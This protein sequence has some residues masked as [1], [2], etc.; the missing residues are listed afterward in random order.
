MYVH[1]NEFPVT[2]T[3]IETFPEALTRK[4]KVIFFIYLFEKF[5]VLDVS[6][7]FEDLYLLQP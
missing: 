7:L 2:P 6:G 4:L 3:F 5:L 1:V